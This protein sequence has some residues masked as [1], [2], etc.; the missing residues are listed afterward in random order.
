MSTNAE[1]DSS[2]AATARTA[3]RLRIG[4]LAVFGVILLLY[5]VGRLGLHIGSAGVLFRSHLGAQPSA[6]YLGDGIML[7]LA[8]AIYWLTAALKSIANGG[9]FTRQTI[10]QFRH[11]ALWLLVMALYS[12]IAPMLL[13]RPQLGKD[14]HHRVMIAL[15]LKDL[16]LIGITGLLFLVTRLLERAGEIEQENREI[17]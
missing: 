13:G 9:L 1:N 7:L 3:A 6:G 5:V 15:D 12:F 17:V 11:F 4:I 8:V 14:M 10:R 16:L 2:N